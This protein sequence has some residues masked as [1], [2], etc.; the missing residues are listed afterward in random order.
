MNR[1]EALKAIEE[2]FADRLKREFCML[3]DGFEGSANAKQIAKTTF[4][5][6]VDIHVD[7]LAFATG[8]IN[9]K[10]KE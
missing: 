2:A 9:A 8:A 6:G 10:F 5:R 4:E 7:A 1:A 3:A